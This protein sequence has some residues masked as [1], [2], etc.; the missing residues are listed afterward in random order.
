MATDS[1]TEL[2][3]VLLSAY[4]CTSHPLSLLLQDGARAVGGR[5]RM[6]CR[7]LGDSLGDL[8]D[9]RPGGARQ[10]EGVGDERVQFAAG[11][12]EARIGG[13]PVQEV[14]SNATAT[15]CS[16]MAS[17]ASSRPTPLR[18]AAISTFVVVRNGR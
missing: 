17:W 11:Q 6:L 2:F 9:L 7:H 8:R 18:T 13:Q 10:V 1:R 4:N 14:I 15:A 12:L 3:C 5:L 16:L